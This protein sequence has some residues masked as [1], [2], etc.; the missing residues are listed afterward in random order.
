MSF[1]LLGAAGMLAVLGLLSLGAFLGWKARG[2]FRP[3]SAQEISEEE[4]RR[5]E[6]EQQAFQSIMGY[7]ADT[8]YGMNRGTDTLFGGENG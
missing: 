4:R 7:N 5:F 2:K 1:F 8:A 6:A 3:P